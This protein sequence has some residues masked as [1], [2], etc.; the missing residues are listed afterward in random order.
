[1]PIR[2]KAM[3][4]DDEADIRAELA[5]YLALQGWEI[6]EAEDCFVAQELLRK[7]KCELMILDIRLP[8]MSGLD[9]LQ[10]L[11]SSFPQMSVIMISGH[12]DMQ[13]VITAMRYGAM[14]YLTKPIN[15]S[16]IDNALQT[17]KAIKAKRQDL[18]KSSAVI[19]EFSALL[20]QQN[21]HQMIGS[22]PAITDIM[23]KIIRIATLDFTDVL[24][25]GES[26]VGKELVARAIHSFGKRKHKPYYAIN[27]SAI[28]EQLF[29]SE[30]FGYVKNAFTGANSD[31][32]GAF[33]AA[34]DGILVL[35][36]ISSLPLPMQSKL[37]RVMEDKHVR[38]IGSNKTLP[39][40]TRIISIT[41]EDLSLA[42]AA[43]R[44][45]K[46][47][48]HRLNTFELNIPPLRAR[49]SDIPLLTEHFI[50]QFAQA[51]NI[52]TS[53]VSGDVLKAMQKYDFPG[54]I[55]ELKNMLRK[56]MILHDEP[57]AD[58]PLKLF[59]DLLLA[60]T[61]RISQ[62]SY[63]DN[64]ISTTGFEPLDKLELLEK[65]WIENALEHYH[66]RVG[67]AA[68]ALGITRFSLTRKMQ[69]HNI[70]INEDEA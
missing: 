24:V 67:K 52:P 45:R 39:I 30:L 4:V 64:S 2:N 63:A 57:G 68:S 29:E 10:T 33:E 19:S 25:A 60:N 38:R 48:Y 28:P 59:P 62:H 14:D 42:C 20:D 6:C 61:A 41:N 47:L 15:L 46:D 8:G 35:D 37:L 1:M 49:K 58:L 66:F 5:D 34:N 43:G 16:D 17:H 44:F 13:S 51:L 9:F 69:K 7:H 54:N 65:K 11:Q 53:I 40:D 22:H 56:A 18:K 12:G 23:E 3:I 50:R 27:C 70:L 55:R 32:A 21:P 26:G 31:K 36:E